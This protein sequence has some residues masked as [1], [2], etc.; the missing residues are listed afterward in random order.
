MTKVFDKQI[1]KILKEKRDNAV[2]YAEKNLKLA[3][4]DKEFADLEKEEIQSIIA[5][6]NLIA[7]GVDQTAESTK[8]NAIKGKKKAR[9]KALGL[10]ERDITPQYSCLKC[11]DRGRSE[12]GVC[13]CRRNI[14]N[15]LLLQ[16]SGTLGDLESFDN[17]KF[18]SKN[19]ETKKIFKLLKDWTE[20]FPDVTK[21]TIYLTGAPGVGKT[22]LLKCVANE[23]L[24][25]GV[26]IFYTTAFKMNNDFL[27]YCWAK[28]EDKN[29]FLAPYLESEVLLLDDLGTEPML[30]N[31]TLDY[32]YL[33][34]NERILNGKTTIINS[35]LDIEQLLERYGERIFSRIVDKRNGLAIKFT[36]EDLRLKKSDN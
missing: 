6:A 8:L 33:I 15:Q 21:N 1:E 24:K 13:D 32:L 23:L 26:F 28:I 14:L 9:L 18:D 19:S 35:N 12:E 3:R 11:E 2:F 20:K 25:K 4:Q 10:E 5:L 27:Q 22:F 31:I 29:E 30:N 17:A 34:L 36:G 16:R 7:E